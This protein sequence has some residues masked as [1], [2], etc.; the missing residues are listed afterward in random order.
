MNPSQYKAGS[1]EARY[2]FRVYGE[3]RNTMSENPTTDEWN[4]SVYLGTPTCQHL[5][6]GDPAFHTHTQ[7]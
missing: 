4:I 2:M 3:I 6:S 5:H 1:V 7:P